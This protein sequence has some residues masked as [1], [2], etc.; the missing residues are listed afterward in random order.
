MALDRDGAGFLFC[1]K[2]DADIRG[3]NHYNP[4]FPLFWGCL[5][6]VFCFV[7]NATQIYAALIIIT[8]TGVKNDL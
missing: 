6:G 8:D 3:I 2:C 1:T 4:S 5:G 7:L